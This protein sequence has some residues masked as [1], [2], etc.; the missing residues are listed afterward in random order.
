MNK[1]AN[2]VIGIVLVVFGLAVSLATWAMWDSMEIRDWGKIAFIGSGFLS[3]LI[4]I[5]GLT[6]SIDMI[7]W[8]TEDSDVH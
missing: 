3:A 1:Q 2:L 8:F 4:G 5:G 7:K 6:N